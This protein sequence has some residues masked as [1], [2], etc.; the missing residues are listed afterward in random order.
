[1]AF[2]GNNAGRV[3]QSRYW[4][5]FGI[6]MITMAL[7]LIG[8]GF[9]ALQGSYGLGLLMIAA[10]APVGIYW[11]VIMMR[12]CR[13]IGWPAAAP[14]ITSA[15]QVAMTLS[16]RSSHGAVGTGVGSAFLLISL[17]GLADFAF[18]IVIG[19]IGTKQAVD[20]GA[21]FGD[22][23]G[24]MQRTQPREGEPLRDGPDRFD[25]AIARALEAH[26]REAARGMTQPSHPV[27]AHLARRSAGFG[28]RA[29]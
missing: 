3:G 19:C 21:I 4:A 8:G 26:R 24:A 28:R 6:T 14:W 23:P 10:I 2:A 13:D 9:A 29:V 18:T 22:G 20:Y 7:L 17:V 15:V 1:M 25:D 5:L 16:L 27:P 12:R 11:R